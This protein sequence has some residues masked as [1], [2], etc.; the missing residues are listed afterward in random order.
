MNRATPI[1]ERIAI[2]RAAQRDWAATPVDRRVAVVAEL[3][4]L[5]AERAPKFVGTVAPTLAKSLADFTAAEVV[6]LVDACR[7][8]ERRAAELL[9][10]R[11]LGKEDR[12]LWLA[13]SEVTIRREPFGLVLIIGPSNY[14]LFL[15]GVQALQALVAG[16]AVLIKP[17][18]NGEQPIRWLIELL[19]DAGL[20]PN[21]VSVTSDSLDDA[22][23]ALRD[24]IDKVVLTGTAET[25]RMVLGRLVDRI[26]PVVLE[27]SGNDPALVL[28]DADLDLAARAIAY[29]L[30][31][32]GSATCI[33][34]R[35]V[36]ALEPIY[37]ALRGRLLA[38]V[39]KLPPIE[40]AEPARTKLAELLDKSKAA[41]AVV[42]G[43]FPPPEG[44]AAMAP[45]VIE[46]VSVEDPL[47]RADIFAPVVM[48]F[49]AADVH[50]A[51]AMA[52]A[53]PYALGASVFGSEYGAREV[54]A[55]INAGAV[56]IND[57]IVPTADPRAPFAGRKQSGY[58][59]TRG[60][61]GLLEM[62]QPKAV[63]LRKGTFRPHFEPPGPD[64]HAFLLSYVAAIH[65][66]NWTTRL[67][68]GMKM[69]RHM[70]ARGARQR[71]RHR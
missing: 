58:G 57:M 33:A 14:P 69:I 32:N 63:F 56:C 2:L 51:V 11:P 70:I 47:A 22:R 23:A 36:I 59:V 41:G 42:H 12:P 61:E 66:R 13:G 39:A 8:L 71:R 3:R 20:P 16:N 28:L 50:E 34:P 38:E 26:I 40:V 52:N 24:Q 67:G 7:F 37:D 45:L 60:S 21:L 48:L 68:A 44:E 49:R 1:H 64:D 31:L 65:G 17:G 6:P 25:G 46:N 19:D 62:T 9:R 35:R 30:R 4:H 18:Q 54:A 10:P 55:R 29:G 53:S 27:L 15:P 43:V 5:I